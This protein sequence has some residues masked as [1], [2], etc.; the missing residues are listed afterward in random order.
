MNENKNINI[1]TTNKNGNKQQKLNKNLHDNVI[2]NSTLKLKLS[3]QNKKFDIPILLNN[4]NNIKSINIINNNYNNIIINNKLTPNKKLML[5]DKTFSIDRKNYKILSLRNK[6]NNLQKETLNLI[7]NKEEQENKIESKY[8]LIINEK[9][10][11]ITKLQNEIEYYK[12]ISKFNHNIPE[13]VTISEMNNN[14]NEEI[15]NLKN[16]IKTLFSQNKNEIKYDNNSLLNKNITNYNT[17]KTTN[18]NNSEINNSFIPFIYQA[19]PIK[20]NSYKV[21]NKLIFNYS[22]KNDLKLKNKITLDL[23]NN[24]NS[25][26]T[27]TNRDYKN[28]SKNT[29]FILTSNSINKYKGNNL[30]LSNFNNSIDRKHSFKN[31]KKKHYFNGIISSPFSLKKEIINKK[32]IDNNFILDSYNEKENSNNDTSS[33]FNYK[34]KYDDLKKRMNNLIENLFKIIEIKNNQKK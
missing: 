30:E 21:N 22:L 27:N 13:N 2:Y 10:S 5:E 31:L 23:S 18:N 6:Q 33:I 26:E 34:E 16:K 1:K 32:I 17:I 12:N 9:N 29:K 24:Y 15:E 14:K 8:K 4:Q 25:I 19:N 20:N 3:H 7:L 28:K 11:L